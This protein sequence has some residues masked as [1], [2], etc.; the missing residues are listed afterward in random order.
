[1]SKLP[2]A[3]HIYCQKKVHFRFWRTKKTFLNDNPQCLR[4]YF[5]TSFLKLLYKLC[6]VFSSSHQW[7]EVFIK[8]YFFHRCYHYVIN[9]DICNN[10]WWY[11]PSIWCYTVNRLAKQEIKQFRQTCPQRVLCIDSYTVFSSI[12]LLTIQLGQF[13]F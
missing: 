4:F 7:K 5:Y 9:H 13:L 8:G 2:E 3:Q 6:S 12:T 10:S 11:A 1:M